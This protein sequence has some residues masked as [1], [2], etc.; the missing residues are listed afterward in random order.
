MLHRNLLLPCD[1]LP[2]AETPEQPQSNDRV[3][4]RLSNGTNVTQNH[5]HTDSEEHSDEE[6]QTGQLTWSPTEP[7]CPPTLNHTAHEFHPQSTPEV[8]ERC[9]SPQTGAN[10]AGEGVGK[11]KPSQLH[12]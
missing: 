3:K 5:Q 4:R 9:Q 8:Q 11:G 10:S 2:V 1:F 12:N 6:F 7:P